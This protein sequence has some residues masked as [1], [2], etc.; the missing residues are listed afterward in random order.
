MRPTFVDRLRDAVD[1][2]VK[3]SIRLQRNQAALDNLNQFA[4]AA[5][6]FVLVYVGFQFTALSFA[7]LGLFLFAVFRLSPV[8]NQINNVTYNLDGRLPSLLRV[9]N[10]IH[11]L[12][13]MD[14]PDSD[15]GT[16]VNSVQNVTLEGVCFTYQDEP[17]LTDVSFSVERGE[18]IALVGPSGAGKSTIVS[19]LGRLQQPDAGHICADDVPIDQ[20]NVEQ[21]R[22]QLAVVRQHPFLFDETLHENVQIGNEDATRR[23]I[24]EACDTAGVTE[25]LP[26]L[27]DGY[28]TELGEDGIRLSGGQKQ[29]VAIARALLKDADVLVLD[30]ATSEL[31][32]NIERDVYQRISHR[33]DEFATITIAH[34]LSTVSDAD[35]IYTLVEGQITEVGTHEQLVSR[36]GTYA[37]LYATQT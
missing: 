7:E 3:D 30:E 2:H 4:N 21:W 1:A 27:P 37:D 19:L 9:R 23:E 34:D 22:E 6:V 11:E 28:E 24:E 12:D 8:V 10:Q 18:K 13:E 15:G 29:R 5:V 16:P 20:L 35:R 17:V 36:D 26:E 25:F 32:S 33:E 31:D 14:V